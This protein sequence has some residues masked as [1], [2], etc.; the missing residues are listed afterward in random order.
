MRAVGWR[1]LLAALPLVGLFLFPLSSLADGDW[2]SDAFYEKLTGTAAVQH[3]LYS[4]EISQVHDDDD[5]YY[6]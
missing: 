3:E 4:G 6:P 5:D 1:S 2:H